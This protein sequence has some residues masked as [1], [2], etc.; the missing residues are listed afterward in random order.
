M[1][2][3]SL[4]AQ[5]P[6]WVAPFVAEHAAGEDLSTVEGRMALVHA[7]ADRNYVE[8]NGGP[9]AA[10]VCSPSGE[11]LSAGVNVVLSS[12]LSSMHAEVTAVSLAQVAAG[13]WDL[14][15]LR[16]GLELTVNWRPCAMCLGAVLWSGVSRLA[17]AGDGPELEELTGF[18]EGPVVTDWVAQLERRGLAVEQD[19]LRDGA[20]RTFRQYRDHVRRDPG[21]VVYN[22]SR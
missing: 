18:D 6:A 4:S 14:G 16:P 12:G 11:L 10:I 17:V 19:V 9:F 2:P 21:T 8:G 15:S 3:T 7:L 1:L 20:L 13:G 22:A 5:L